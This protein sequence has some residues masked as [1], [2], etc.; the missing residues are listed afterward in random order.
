VFNKRY[1]ELASSSREET[2]LGSYDMP[3][4]DIPC[5][6]GENLLPFVGITNS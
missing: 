1:K 4:E 2:D 6:F 3:E 5:G